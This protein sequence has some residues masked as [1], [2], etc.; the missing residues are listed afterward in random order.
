M[1]R[2][3]FRTTRIFALAFTAIVLGVGLTQVSTTISCLENF[4]DSAGFAGQLLRS[5]GIV[6]RAESVLTKDD[7]AMLSSETWDGNGTNAEWTTNDNWAGIGGAGANDDLTFPQTAAR[8]TSHNDFPVNTNFNSLNFQGPDYVITGNQI[9]LANGIFHNPGGGVSAVFNP[10][11]ILGADQFFTNATNNPSPLTLNG[12]VNLNGH[13]LTIVPGGT[14]GDDAIVMNGTINGTGTLVKKGIGTAILNGNSPNF[15]TTIIE[16]A[17]S[18]P[19]GTLQVGGT[20]GN[21]QLSS[22]KLSGVGTVGSIDANLPSG[23]NNGVISPGNGT[24]V[25]GILTAAGS[26]EFASTSTFA[27]NLNGTAVGTGYDRLNVTSGHSIALNGANLNV[28][29]GFTPLPGQQFTI[30]QIL[31]SGGIIGQFQQGTSL[32]VNGHPFT[33]GYLS[34]SVVL[35]EASA[36]SNTQFDYD[37]DHKTDISVFRPSTGDWFL[38]RSQSGLFGMSFGVS[39]DK[40]TPADY[41]GDGKTDIAVYRPSTG[42][43]Y[44]F[45]SSN[46]TVSFNVF[47]VA[48]DLPT[49]A[50]YDGDGR[51]D[52]SVFRPSTG[53]WHRQNS[54]NGSFFSVQFGTNGDKPTVGDFDGDHKAD[55]AVYRPSSGIWFQIRSLSGSLFG[56]QFGL[57]S[58]LITPSDYDGDGM[59]DLAVYRPS[60]GTWFIKNSSNSSF[61]FS[62]FGLAADIPVA[63]DFDGDGRAD[64]SV[65]RP[66]DGTWYRQNS[67]NGT[68]NAFQFG[69]N[70]D[71]P[72]PSVFRY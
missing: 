31:G 43:W 17:G 18:V 15:G 42:I 63:G 50:D 24:N 58:D 14:T 55:I 54:G 46:G 8:K 61:T 51:A 32:T 39:T 44:V 16:T 62:V 35:T 22:G 59:T 37:G 66:T 45:N 20:L 13:V 48:E 25:A 67:S 60:T 64:I 26:V 38:Q 9:F 69:T 29:L 52:I 41:D 11:I 65:F 49:P 57:S 40:I 70:G 6:A 30:M 5:T 28:S 71:K 53:T 4:F 1:K 3:N 19:A 27:V 23:P 2:S 7:D 34:S 56:E 10:N 33:I 36:S 68:F 72:T 12:V 47:G 21:I